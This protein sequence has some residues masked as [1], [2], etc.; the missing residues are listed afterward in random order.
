MNNIQSKGCRKPFQKVF[1]EHSTYPDD[2]LLC[3]FSRIG[4]EV[5]YCDECK[6]DKDNSQETNS[7]NN[8]LHTFS[9]ESRQGDKSL[10]LFNSADYI[11]EDKI[12]YLESL[13]QAQKD[14]LL[15]LEKELE[16]LKWAQK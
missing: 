15:T 14:I 9:A 12:K 5:Q 1:I 2:Y 16:K 10:P 6:K 13:I 11:L 4:N 8:S 7:D 3:G